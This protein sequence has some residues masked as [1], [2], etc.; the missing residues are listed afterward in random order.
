[1]YELYM[2]V[3]TIRVENKTYA[4]I[5]TRVPIAD[6][7]HTR[8]RGRR[9]AVLTEDTLPSTSPSDSDAGGSAEWQ[10]ANMLD[11]LPLSR[12]LRPFS[13]EDGQQISDPS[14]SKSSLDNEGLVVNLTTTALPGEDLYDT[15]WADY[16]YDYDKKV[17]TAAA[18]ARVRIDFDKFG[19]RRKTSKDERGEEKD[20]EDLPRDIYCDLVENL[21]DLCLQTNLLE[22]WRYDKGGEMAQIS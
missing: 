8:Q 10:P 19:I 11:N 4:D 1:M 6:I 22:I 16:D 15:L 9:A 3:M 17:A 14:S 18:A 5:C 20:G 12:S 2:S 7:F 13:A 21:E